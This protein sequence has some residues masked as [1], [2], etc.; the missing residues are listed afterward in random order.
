M[1]SYT[2]KKGDTLISI[3]HDHN[4]QNWETIWNDDQNKEL[5][6]KRDPQVLAEGDKVFVPEKKPKEFRIQ[7]GKRHVFVAQTL[8]A[9]FRTV[10]KDEYGQ[11]LAN[12]RFEL[13]IEGDGVPTETLSGMTAEDG[14]I[15]LR[16]H[17]KASKGNLKV[18][19]D[20]AN[21]RDLTWNLNLGNLDPIDKLSG[22]K[23]R[24][25]NLGF[26]CGAI[27]EEQN[28]ETTKAL[29][30]FQIVNR[31]EVTGIANNE[32]KKMLMYLHDKR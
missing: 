22:I 29:K 1:P 24:L 9:E 7:T 13:K 4:F 17:P 5:R 31:L 6:E 25:T 32:T 26:L 30:S 11:P 16:I 2:V 28:E 19:V 21:D 20:P 8:K 3:A 27:D 15:D 18:F 14:Q 12:T 23:A 10:V